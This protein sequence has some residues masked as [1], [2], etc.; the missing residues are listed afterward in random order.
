[1]KIDLKVPNSLE[2]IT[3][4][5]YQEFVKVQSNTNDPEFL[6][7]KMISIF[8]E[9][10]LSDVLNI[11][12]SSIVEIAQHFTDIFKEESPLKTRFKF[13]GIDFGFIPKL[14]DISFGEYI[15]LEQHLQNWEDYH[16]AL[17]VLYRPVKNTIGDKY[18]I[19]DYTID[20]NHQE[21]MK[22]IP[23]S[24][25]L[26]STLFFCR[27][28]RELSVL[29]LDSLARKE[30]EKQK[31]TSLQGQSL[32]ESGHGTNQYTQL[33][34]ETSRNLMRLQDSEFMSALPILPLKAKK[35]R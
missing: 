13:N 10:P 6:A 28:G 30:E 31:K 3:V 24:V 12:Y 15:D 19:R 1:M 4:G 20:E 34:K 33:L 29:T 27:L 23:V 2:E 22:H 18:S 26:G 17:A 21:L 9:I 11:K 16:K 25:A 32:G 7:Q 14:D 8:C 35:T 5:Q